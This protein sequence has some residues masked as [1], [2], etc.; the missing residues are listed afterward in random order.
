MEPYGI[1]IKVRY[2]GSHADRH[3]VYEIV[4]HRDNRLGVPVSEIPEYTDGVAYDLWPV[5]VPH[6]FGNYDR[7][8]YFARRDSLTPEPAR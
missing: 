6:K 3:G 2:H 5:G 7:A 1:G 4:G 8:L